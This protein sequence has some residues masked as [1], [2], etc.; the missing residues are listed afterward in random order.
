MSKSITVTIPYEDFKHLIPSITNVV[1]TNTDKE[2]KLKLFLISLYLHVHKCKIDKNICNQLWECINSNT[3]IDD[4]ILFLQSTTSDVIADYFKSKVNENVYASIIEDDDF[5]IKLINIIAAD[6]ENDHINPHEIDDI[7][8]T[9]KSSSSQQPSLA[10]LV[11]D[12]TFETLLSKMGINE[13]GKIQARAIKAEM[14][15]GKAPDMNK[16]MAFVQKYKQNFDSSNIDLNTIYK[17]MTGMS[18][19]NDGSTVKDAEPSNEAKTQL[20]FD[21]NNV[22]NMVNAL[23]ANLNPQK[24]RRGRRR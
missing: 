7:V 3:I 12:E 14:K 9:Y 21:L 6:E 24:S 15:D 20:P 5:Y 19:A 16:V 18:S 8:N 13:E 23:S 11:T 2:E 1:Y 22:M 10:D 17:M 4:C